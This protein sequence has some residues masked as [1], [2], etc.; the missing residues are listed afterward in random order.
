MKR[1]KFMEVDSNTRESCHVDALLHNGVSLAPDAVQEF[2][3]IESMCINGM[4]KGDENAVTYLTNVA[5]I[6]PKAT[7]APEKTGQFTNDGSEPSWEKLAL[8]NRDRYDDL[9]VQTAECIENITV[10][11]LK[12]G[13]ES[14]GV[15][16]QASLAAKE[17]VSSFVQSE[18]HIIIGDSIFTATRMSPISKKPKIGGVKS[19]QN[20]TTGAH[21]LHDT[22]RLLA[23]GAERHA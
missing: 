6:N 3:Q 2:A 1:R 7:V 17:P 12:D 23:P 10:D 20:M 11:L 4:C 14:L 21:R 19:N 18:Q 8:H 9:Q 16:Q 13:A 22:Q 5:R 15:L